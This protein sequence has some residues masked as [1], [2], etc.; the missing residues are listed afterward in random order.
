MS[1]QA[2]RSSRQK[3]T[4]AA[5]AA[6]AAERL[7]QQQQQQRHT[8]APE[9]RPAGVRQQRQTETRRDRK[10]TD[11]GTERWGR[12]ESC[13]T[14]E[15]HRDRETDAQQRGS[16]SSRDEDTQ[17][18]GSNDSTDTAAEAAE[19]KRDRAIAA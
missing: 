16:C 15:G 4:R 9:V 14:D 13:E 19:H 12:G 3:H 7:Q 1:L 18:E 10:K 8:A 6:A 2:P 5:E 11:R 17:A